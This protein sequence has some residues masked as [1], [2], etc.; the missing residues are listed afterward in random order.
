[1]REGPFLLLEGEREAED[2]RQGSPQFVGDGLKEGVLH[3]VQVPEAI[4][5]FLFTTQRLLH[6]L[7]CALQLGDVVDHALEQAWTTIR[8]A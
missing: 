5:G 8:R 3:L 2:R 4:G 1:M 6:R 7:S